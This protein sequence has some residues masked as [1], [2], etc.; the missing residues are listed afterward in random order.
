MKKLGLVTFSNT[1]DNYGQMLQTLATIEFFKHRGYDVYLLRQ[2]LPLIN[3][4]KRKTHRILKALGLEA[5]TDFDKWRKATMAELERHPREFELFREKHFNLLRIKSKDVKK[6]HFDLVV[7]GSDQIWATLDEFMFMN[8]GSEVPRVSIAPGVGLQNYNTNQLNRIYGYIKDYRFITVREEAGRLMCEKIGLKA[9]VVL[10][11]TFLCDSSCY[12][13]Y[14]EDMHIQEDYIL[15]Y[16][17]GAKS[18]L[19]LDVIYQFAKTNNLAVKYVASQGRMDNYEKIYATLPQWLYLLKHAKYVV[20]NSFHGMALSII[21]KKLF[22]SL[23]IVSSTKAMNDRIE[24]LA[25]VFELKERLYSDDMN[26]LF[27]PLDVDKIDTAVKN[28][29]QYIES[30]L[31]KEGF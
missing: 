18:A 25:D 10:D 11:P 14:A 19:E 15:V 13:R 6:Q 1:Y 17:L 30:L 22:L 5:K 16:M 8:F 21:Y 31:D 7:A 27:K 29:K 3:W 9:D 4:L 12:D 24:H 2:K 26:V 28:N 20:T 23:P